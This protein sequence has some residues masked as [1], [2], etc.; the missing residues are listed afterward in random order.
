[1]LRV[2]C[3]FKGTNYGGPGFADHTDRQLSG[4]WEDTEGI[5][6]T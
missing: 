3:Y 5:D 4:Q 6:H 2:F 1:M